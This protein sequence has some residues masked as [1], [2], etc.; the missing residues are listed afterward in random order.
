MDLP[1]TLCA[2]TIAL[3]G[4]RAWRALTRTYAMTELAGADTIAWGTR[5][6]ARAA[7]HIM[8]P[9]VAE[10]LGATCWCPI[11]TCTDQCEDHVLLN[12]IRPVWIFHL[13]SYC[14]ICISFGYDP[15]HACEMW[16]LLP[17]RH[18]YLCY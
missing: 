15:F 9:L 18:T 4:T 2:R 1:A 6:R 17:V 11:C 10:N 7:V 8:R 3:A 5:T 14:F 12:I 13:Q 16:W